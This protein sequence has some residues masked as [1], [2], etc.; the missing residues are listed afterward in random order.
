[1][2][3]TKQ[4]LAGL[5]QHAWQP[6]LAVKADVP[7]DTKTCERTDGAA[8]A[9]QAMHRD[10][11]SANLVDS[12]PKRSTSFGDD[13]TGPPAPPCSRDD[14]LVGNGFASPKSC[15]SSLEM[16]TPTAAG[17][18]LL[19]SKTSTAT[20]TI[21]HQLPLWFCPPEEMNLGTLI[22]YATYYSTFWRINTQQAG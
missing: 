12:D 3:A 1:M 11:Y 4:R 2:R 13:F 14:A 8:A 15:L 6:R 18:L 17:G 21:L 9:V 16:R 7:S 5:Q 20:I 19:T 10:S 22:Q